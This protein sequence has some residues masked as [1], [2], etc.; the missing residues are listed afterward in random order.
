MTNEGEEIDG[1]TMHQITENL[2]DS[3][4]E[5]P[6]VVQVG[7]YYKIKIGIIKTQTGIK[8]KFCNVTFKNFFIKWGLKM[9]IILN[10]Y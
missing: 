6:I 4:N 3:N 1:P 9:V 10:I 5:G 2:A 7:L 8:L